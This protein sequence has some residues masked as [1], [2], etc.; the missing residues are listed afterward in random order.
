[1]K[2]IPNIAM[3]NFIENNKTD[4]SVSVIDF[5]FKPEYKKIKELYLNNFGTILVFIK[6]YG[7]KLALEDISNLDSNL[8]Q[9]ITINREF[10]AKINNAISKEKLHLKDLI[11][12]N[13]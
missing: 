8:T 11:D 4:L 10:L 2:N 9:S 5:L 7:R 1:M 6:K 3:E 12:S 13:S